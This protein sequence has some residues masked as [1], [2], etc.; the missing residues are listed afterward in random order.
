MYQPVVLVVDDDEDIRDTVAHMLDVRGFRVFAAADRDGAL[1]I[2]RELNGDVDVLVAD[3]SLPGDAGGALARDV[4]ARCPSVKVVFVTGIPRHIA[5]T[6][7][8]VQPD[9]PYLQKPV[10]PD[11]LAA[12]LRSLLPQYAPRADDW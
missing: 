4:A 7:G 8:L 10:N 12:L 2:C 6:M 9:A 3:L 5:L 1:S 11:V